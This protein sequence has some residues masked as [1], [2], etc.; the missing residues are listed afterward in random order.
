MS[1]N[2]TSP[3]RPRAK[4]YFSQVLVERANRILDDAKAGVP[5]SMGVITWALRIT[6]DI[7]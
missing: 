6:G 4:R 1:R 2:R 7:A 3:R 5:T